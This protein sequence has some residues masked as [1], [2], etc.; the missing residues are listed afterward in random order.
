MKPILILTIPIIFLLS[1]QKEKPNNCPSEFEING[2]IEPYDSLY[3]VGDTL[4]LSISFSKFVIEKK[5]NKNYNLQNIAIDFDPSF[6][7]IRIDSGDYTQNQK[8]D[9]YTNV[10]SC[11]DS[12]FFW[13]EFASDGNRILKTHFTFQNDSFYLNLQISVKRKGLFILEFGESFDNSNSSFEGKC[14][15]V[16]FELHTRLNP[17]TDNNINLLKQSSFEYFNKFL[18]SHQEKFYKRGSYVFKVV[19]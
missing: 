12:N 19:N 7:V 13:Y 3:G 5:L 1:C 15:N 8:T 9:D 14:P 18:L 11:S 6:R 10:I 16:D 2:C 4:E 17:P